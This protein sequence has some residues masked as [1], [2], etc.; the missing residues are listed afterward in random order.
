ML[1]G[2]LIKNG[3]NQTHLVFLWWLQQ[4]S[5]CFIQGGSF[6]TFQVLLGTVALLHLSDTADLHNHITSHDGVNELSVQAA[7]EAADIFHFVFYL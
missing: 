6:K 4:S 2:Q 7:G 5:D 1:C 3:P